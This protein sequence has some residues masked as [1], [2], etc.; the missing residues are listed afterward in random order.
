MSNIQA[1]ELV[2]VVYKDREFFLIPASASL[3]YSEKN[4]MVS[5]VRDIGD[6]AFIVDDEVYFDEGANFN[7]TM[8]YCNKYVF[9]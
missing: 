3:S 5:Y 1:I 7:L 6:V 4:E 9:I 2:K 8:K